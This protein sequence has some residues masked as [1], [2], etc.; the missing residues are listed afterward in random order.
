MADTYTS[1]LGLTKPGY[2][3]PVDVAVINANM[4]KIDDAV[5]NAGK[6]KSVNG[7]TGDVTIDD[8]PKLNGKSADAYL[9]KSGGTMSG[10]LGMGGY[11]VTNLGDAVNDNDAVHLKYVK[12]RLGLLNVKTLKLTSEYNTAF[13]IIQ[14]E[15][16]NLSIGLYIL[17]IQ[18]GSYGQS[19]IAFGEKT[20][21]KYGSFLVL[22]YGIT[23]PLYY[24]LYNSIW[25][26]HT[27]S[28]S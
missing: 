3:S 15:Y 11:R 23:S 14:A 27:V 13:A 12:D 22:G 6:V 28:V 1:N 25:N 20:N 10:A 17:M 21:D 4:D 9:L 26:E 2:D 19:G 18:G 8:V 16:A 5:A 7:K 24:R